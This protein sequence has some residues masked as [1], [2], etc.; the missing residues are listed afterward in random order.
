V[1]QYYG[2]G[3]ITDKQAAA[4]NFREAALQ[5]HAQA[6]TN[7]AML[8]EAG[9][10]VNADAAA[11]FAWYKRAADAGERE[12]CF[13]AG[14][15]LH[16]S[17]VPNYDEHERVADAFH[18]FEKAVNQHHPQSFYY[19]GT[20][21]EYGAHLPQDFLTAAALY[22]A[23]CTEHRDADCCYHLGLLH[24][25]GRGIPQDWA[26]A[27]SIWQGNVNAAAHAPSAL[28]LGLMYANGQGVSADYDLARMYLQQA[29]RSGD[30]RVAAE[31]TEAFTVLDGLMERAESGINATLKAVEQQILAAP[32]P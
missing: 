30:V 6:A 15:M 18:F 7:F 11:A 22:D 8:L 31:A 25:F 12:A 4:K 21:Y 17:R 1:L 2:E 5:G 23:G 28:Y 3:I 27:V 20:L 14:L 9:H 32:P 13:R 16:E 10:G 24:A 26:A 19:L 29:A